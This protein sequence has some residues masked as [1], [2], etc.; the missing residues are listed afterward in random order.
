M[1]LQGYDTGF[2]SFSSS[3]GQYREKNYA[4]ERYVWLGVWQ[5]LG[6]DAGSPSAHT[7]CQSAP[8]LRSDN[9]YIHGL[10]ALRQQG[11]K[12]TYKQYSV[13]ISIKWRRMELPMPFAPPYIAR[14]AHHA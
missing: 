11:S 8:E 10:L 6:H 1:A 2:S 12:A 4:D 13:G 14:K 5:R 7:A 3:D 9:T